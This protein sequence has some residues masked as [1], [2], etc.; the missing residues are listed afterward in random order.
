MLFTN[1][2]SDGNGLIDISEF[3]T[4]LKRAASRMA[5]E[6]QEKKD[7]KDP[8]SNIRLIT[9]MATTVSKDMSVLVPILPPT[10]GFS[11]LFDFRDFTKGNPLDH[12]LRP[13]R[14]KVVRRKYT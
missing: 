11:A 5:Q 1:L 14:H 13:I 3:S 7:E 8:R 6:E 10:V 9:L 2:D 12:R 4:F